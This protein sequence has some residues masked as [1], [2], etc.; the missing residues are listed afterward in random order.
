MRFRLTD[1]AVLSAA[2]RLPMSRKQEET[3]T[4]DRICQELDN[5]TGFFC[6]V[7]PYTFDLDLWCI[8][9]IS[10]LTLAPAYI[11]TLIHSLPFS[12]LSVTESGFLYEGGTAL[13]LP[14]TN[15]FRGLLL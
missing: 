10:L 8:S 15:K 11:V 13:Y 7:S 3:V 5:P 1:T 2:G 12:L 9:E 6:R 4:G 14:Y